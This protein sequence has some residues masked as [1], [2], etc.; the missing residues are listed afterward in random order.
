MLMTLLFGALALTFLVCGRWALLRARG[1]LMSSGSITPITFAA[2]FTSYTTLALGVLLA[3]AFGVG[4]PTIVP[5]LIR[6]T[7]IVI[8]F[9]G[10]ALYLVARLQ[11][12]SFKRTWGLDSST[13]IVSGIY[14]RSRHPQ[15]VGWTALLTGLSL[16]SGSAVAFAFTACFVLAS[17]VW[18]PVEEAAMLARFG[19]RYASYRASTRFL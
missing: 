17:A 1:E 6:A 16:W 4:S 9:A 15:V 7:G 19:D 12:R 5:G 3:A 10:A 13:L 2:A 18:L 11:L 8:V 14:S